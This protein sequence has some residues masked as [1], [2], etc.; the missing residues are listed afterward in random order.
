M[1]TSFILTRSRV[2]VKR[3][4]GRLALG[5]GSLKGH[6]GVIVFRMEGFGGQ[7][8]ESDVLVLGVK[9]HVYVV[10]SEK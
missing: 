3:L 2:P 1:G 10:V 4:F 7:R 9:R 5:L 6:L 8:E